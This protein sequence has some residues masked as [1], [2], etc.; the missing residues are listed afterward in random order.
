MHCFAS[1]FNKFSL[2]KHV[3]FVHFTCIKVYSRTV[4]YTLNTLFCK[5]FH[6][7][8]LYSTAETCTLDIFHMYTRIHIYRT[9]Y[10]K[11]TGLQVFS[12]VF[13]KFLLQKHVLLVHLTCTQEYTCTVLYPRNALFC[14]CFYV[15]S[16]SFHCRN[17][18]FWCISHVHKNTHVPYFIH[19]MHC[20]ASVFTKFLLQK[21]VLLIHF[22]CKQ[23]YTCTVLYT[24][25]A[26]FC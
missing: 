21:H 12:C 11:C 9:L 13:T 18:Y 20:F 10:M 3:L 25:N 5:C 23:E 24:W 14:L 16:R 22:T 4:L 2:Q 26:L 8:L 15:F 19:E 7:L 6:G 1:V 17:M